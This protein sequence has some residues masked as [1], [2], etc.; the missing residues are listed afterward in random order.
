MS[1]TIQVT[2]PVCG[3]HASHEGRFIRVPYRPPVHSIRMKPYIWRQ[4]RTH[5]RRYFPQPP[6]GL[7]MLWNPSGSNKLTDTTQHR[8]RPSSTG[9]ASLVDHRVLLRCED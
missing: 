1:E 5:L 3:A 2:C 9:F 7:L 8:A 4:C 6:S